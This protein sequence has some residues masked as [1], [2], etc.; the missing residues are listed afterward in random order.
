M[1]VGRT[2]PTAASHAAAK[3]ANPAAATAG[4]PRQRVGTSSAASEGCSSTSYAAGAG[5]IL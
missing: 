3:T 1:T 5:G 2:A 4:T